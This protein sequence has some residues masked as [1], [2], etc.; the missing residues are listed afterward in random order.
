M[1]NSLYNHYIIRVVFSYYEKIGNTITCIDDELPFE[2]PDNWAWIRLSSACIINPKNSLGDDMLVSFV[3]MTLIQEGY[4]NIF[5]SEQKKW[6]EV[7]KGFTH[8]AENDVGFAKITPCFEN[9]KSVV[10]RGLR[11]GYGAG[12]TELYI[13]R[14]ISDTIL[15][16]YILCVVKTESFLVGGK[17]TCA[18]VVGQQ[19]ISKDF[20]CNYLIPVPPLNEQRKIIKKCFEIMKMLHN[21]EKSLS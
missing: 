20:V 14:T 11:N 3:P 10:F 1:R 5:T 9:R 12:T 15:P 18:G 13:L 21:I 2:I 19:R 6:G 17:Q 16:E 8:F 4:T 7:K